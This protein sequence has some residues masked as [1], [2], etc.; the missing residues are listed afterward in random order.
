MT[1]RLQKIFWFS[2]AMT[3]TM[4]FA[5]QGLC[6]TSKRD[7]LVEIRLCPMV[8]TTQPSVKLSE[9]AAI[10]GD[11]ELTKKLKEI[12]LCDNLPEG[13][14]KTFRA[15]Q[16]GGK[17]TELG[18]H[19]QEFTLTGASRCDVSYV[20]PEKDNKDNGE[21]KLITLVSLKS[22]ENAATLQDKIRLLVIENLLSK[23]LPKTAQVNT[24]F[25]STLK[26]LLELS[27]PTYSFEISPNQ[28]NCPWIGLVGLKV[29]IF[30]DGQIVHNIPV[31][32]QVQ[33]K[34][35][36]V[37]A[38]KTI[39]SKAR[40]AR[41]DIEVKPRTMDSFSSDYLLTVDDVLDHRAKKII[42]Q[43]MMIQTGMIETIPM[44]KR[45]QLVTVIYRKG[46]LE[47]KMVGKA[48]QGAC[49]NEMISVRNENSKETFRAKVIDSGLVIVEDTPAD[50][51]DQPV[52]RSDNP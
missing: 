25:N 46:G 30:R 44:I 52:M 24:D 39:N 33:V 23:G 22:N 14:T 1:I 35:P 5:A 6:E 27:E 36:V 28:K 49:K 15:W 9:L 34:V 40:I 47:L 42:Q 45:N 51:Q 43:G 18:F 32:V 7:A 17:L 37:I 19:Y 20:A 3:M 31:L 11:Q 29:K 8:T 16:I 4:L 48:L 2:M 41:G 12:I 26:D 21:S 38:A 10:S 13:E 50:G